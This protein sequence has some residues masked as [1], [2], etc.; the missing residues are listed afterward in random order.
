LLH[1]WQIR[2][3][4]AQMGLI[5][6]SALQ[7]QGV[8]RPALTLV[9]RP[10][11]QEILPPD[12]WACL[13]FGSVDLHDMRL[14]RRV[15]EMAGKMAVLAD[16]SLPNQMGS[17]AALAGAYRLLN[18][19]AVTLAALLRPH[20]EQ[21]L[22]AARATKLVL[23]AEDTSELDF[24]NHR[25]MEGLGPIGDG[26]GRGILLHTTL[27]II[28][29]GR[30][31][32]GVAHAQVVLRQPS[33]SKNAHWTRSP[34]AMV[35]E[36]SATAV[37]S[38]PEGVTWVHVSDRGGDEFPY[39]AACIDH[40]KHFLIRA[41]HDRVL[42]W[43]DED[44]QGDEEW[45]HTVLHYARSLP[46]HPAAG[47]TVHVPKHKKQ[48]AREAKV[49]L[50]WAPIT[51]P[52]PA[53]GPRELRQHPPLS[54][55]VLRVWEPDPPAAAE[56]VEWILL[57]SLPIASVADAYRT[58]DWYTCRWIC[59]D[60]HMCLKTGCRIEESQLDDGADIRR[61]LGFLIP[62]ATRLL[63]LRR[64]ARETPNLLASIVVE[65][66]MVEVLARRQK[67]NARTMTVNAFWR[68]VAQ[69]GGHLG[70][71]CDGPPGWRTVWRGYHKLLEWTEGA[72]LFAP[73]LL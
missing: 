25:A 47:Y 29:E 13:N 27:A 35:W 58:I 71:R 52:P 55:W 69:L 65:P 43:N 32:L 4:E 26:K 48:A 51:I 23:M 49:V 56:R 18:N 15:V 64:A 9:P 34:E 59:E 67:M 46:P 30:Q 31:V 68:T 33:R 3:K 36:V 16:G 37:G 50:Q 6:G 66:L 17:P 20:C 44:P 73:D 61:L 1:V 54:A 11:R 63:Q 62:L 19:D 40:G 5:V 42:H 38:P 45:A 53:Q 60:Y 21:T 7:A 28:P 12:G 57:S 24:T 70:R 10:E 14:N 72:R 8:E 39:M 41:F 2:S 22:A